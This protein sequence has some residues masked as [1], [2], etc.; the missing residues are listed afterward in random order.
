MTLSDSITSIK[1]SSP[2]WGDIGDALDIMSET[3]IVLIA[4][5]DTAQTIANMT[6][7]TVL[8]DNVIKEDTDYITYN[9]GTGIATI[10]KAGHYL[11]SACVMW[12]G[13]VIGVRQ[14]LLRSSVAGEVFGGSTINAPSTAAS[15]PFLSVTSCKKN[16]W[17][18]GETL[19]SQVYQSSGGN[20]DLVVVVG[21]PQWMSVIRLFD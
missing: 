18:V 7:A 11:I 12:A 9:T 16:S 4:R 14:L 6:D 15:R 2:K 8:F 3:R 21:N 19:I 5:R 17:V 20:L 13:N 10:V 1:S